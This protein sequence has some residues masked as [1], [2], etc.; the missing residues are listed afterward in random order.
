MSSDGEL[1]FTEAGYM[2]ITQYLANW[3]FRAPGY[4]LHILLRD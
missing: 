4:G 1:K 3:I 2:G